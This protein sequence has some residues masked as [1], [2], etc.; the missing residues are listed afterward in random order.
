MPRVDAKA[1]V[2]FGRRIEADVGGLLEQVDGFGRRIGAG[3][4]DER[5]RLLVFLASVRP[6]VLS[7]SSGPDL[8]PS[9]SRGAC[10]ARDGQTWGG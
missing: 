9:L 5:E 6:A 8:E 3:P 4:I 2:G 7:F 1:N 10:V